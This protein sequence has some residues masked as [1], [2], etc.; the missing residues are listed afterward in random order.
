MI[1]RYSASVIRLLKV[2]AILEFHTSPDLIVWPLLC[3]I[4]HTPFVSY[5][6]T[7][8]TIL[9]CLSPY[10]HV[11][12]LESRSQLLDAALASADEANRRWEDCRALVDQLRIENAALRSALSQLQ[13]QQA[14][15]G[16]TI[17]LP[18]SIAGLV[19]NGTHSTGSQPPPPAAENGTDVPSSASGGQS[20]DTN[21]DTSAPPVEPV[22]QANHTNQSKECT[23]Q[24]TQE[25]PAS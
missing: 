2:R 25:K 10:R 15:A 21:V 20:A 5:R 13:Q 23:A 17:P 11:K 24:P 7:P 8:F 12:A 22:D 14:T 16:V 19:Q 3:H 4:P 6:L 1:V 18:I 9:T